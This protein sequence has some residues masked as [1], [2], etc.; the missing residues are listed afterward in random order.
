[1][2]NRTPASGLCAHCTSVLDGQRGP[3]WACC[4]SSD[5]DR[6]PMARAPVKEVLVT[7]EMVFSYHLLSC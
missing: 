6:V 2:F 1:M 7:W 4:L 5:M 3:P